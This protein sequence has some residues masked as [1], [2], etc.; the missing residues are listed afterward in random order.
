MDVREV[1]DQKIW[2]GFVASVAPGQFLQSWA[3]GEFQTAL[4]RAVVRLAVCEGDRII[5]GVQA[6]QYALPFNQNYWYVPRGSVHTDTKN[7]AA[8]RLL[9]SALVEKARA[10][11]SLCIRKEPS[12]EKENCPHDY[13]SRGF[14]QGP[15]MQPADTLILDL[16]QPLE[17]IEAG[18]HQKTRYNIH[19]AERKGVNAFEA[20][21]EQ[22]L[23]DFLA[24]QS[25]T[26]QRDKIQPFSDSY[27]QQMYQALA[28]AGQLSLWSAEYQGSL[29]AINLII[30][31]GDTV[32]YN[33]GASSDE[34][35]NLMAP[36]LLQWKT[37]QWAKEK[38]FRHYDFRG[39]APDDNPRHAWAGITRFKKGF[40][41][42]AVHY[43][44]CYDFVLNSAWYR[45]YRLGQAIIKIIR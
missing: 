7:V 31:F 3:W 44:G 6:I 41:G 35:R 28:P 14:I 23:N 38:G 32:S 2:D 27:F 4:G 37:I 21:T 39:I 11:Q 30:S 25:V 16:R 12:F 40:G 43:V 22:S 34:Q 18:L 20:T 17:Q 19:L 26:A 13:E 5:V 15:S 8:C 1:T 10:S 36:H 29:L 33:H 9:H 24:L 45:L 42:R